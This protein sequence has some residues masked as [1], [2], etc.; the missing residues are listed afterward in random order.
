MSVKKPRPN[1][2]HS[3]QKCEQLAFFGREVDVVVELAHGMI[4]RRMGIARFTKPLSVLPGKR[5]EAAI[6]KLN[7]NTQGETGG[8]PPS[9]ARH[10]VGTHTYEPFKGG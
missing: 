6:G 8:N 1:L 4:S 7:A 3:P 10:I 9:A 2:E 5:I